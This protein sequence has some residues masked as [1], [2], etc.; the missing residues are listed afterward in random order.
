MT[1]EKEMTTKKEF[2]DMIKVVG[3]GK[4][5][6]IA[7]IPKIGGKRIYGEWEQFSIWTQY[8]ES[9][10]ED[11]ISIQHLRRVNPPENISDISFQ[12]EDEVDIDEISSELAN[13]AI[14]KLIFKVPL[15]TKVLLPR[16]VV[17]GLHGLQKEPTGYEWGGGIDFEIIKGKPQIER[18][19]A[20][21][22]EVKRMPWRVIKKYGNDVEVKFHTHPNRKLANPSKSDILSFI[23]AKQQVQLI[24]SKFQIL[25]LY[26]TKN[27]PKSLEK[28]DIEER[29]P[30]VGYVVHNYRNQKEV[31]EIMRKEYKINYNLFAY[32]NDVAIDLEVVRKVLK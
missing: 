9:Y 24:V 6:D 20:Y 26:K 32:P 13:V 22:G 31:L 23:H 17:E 7:L 19:L 3:E 27:T 12:D 29:T 18:L 15:E 16:S 5:I 8:G 11:I 28:S 2:L 21:F 4:P 14:S 30:N 10:E 1:T 25:V